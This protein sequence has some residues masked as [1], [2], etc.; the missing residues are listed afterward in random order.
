MLFLIVL[1]FFLTACREEPI[2][3]PRGYFRIALPE[4]SYQLSDT[5]WPYHFAYP[6]Y[7]RFL[8]D[9]REGSEAYWANIEVPE[10]KASIHLS[11]KKVDGNLDHYTEDARSLAM[12]HIAKSTS[13]REMQISRPEADVYGMVYDIRG[14]ETASPFQF[15]VTDSLRHFLRGALYFNHQPNND[16]L[17]PVIRFLE[18]DM[19]HL[20]RTLHWEHSPLP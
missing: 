13:I 19:Y 16:S 17:A 12:K 1:I 20:L 9:S 18:E 10:Y 11:Y 4:K 7:A 8:P 2:P 5:S 14:S 15:Y 6:E 3:K